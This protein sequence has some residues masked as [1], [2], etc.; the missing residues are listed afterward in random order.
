Q[1]I[2]G[3]II[4]RVFLALVFGLILGF[5]RE[6]TK[7]HEKNYGV[8]GMRTHT[9]VAMGAALVSAIGALAF[10]ADPIRLAA[11]ILT[12]IGFIGAGTILANSGRIKGL[13]NAATIWLAASIGIAVGLGFLATAFVATIFSILVLELRRFE[14]ID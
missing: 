8:A 12:G 5:Q 3:V 4:F 7:V 13:V 9:I 1:P 14:K 11:S 10:A 2:E 6:S